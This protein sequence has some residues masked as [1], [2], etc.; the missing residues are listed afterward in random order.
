MK[1]HFIVLAAAMMPLAFFSCRK[2]KIEPRTDNVSLNEVA[3]RPV[4]KPSA[5]LDSGLVGRYEFDGNLKEYSGKLADAVASISGADNYTVDRKGNVNRAIKFNGRYGLDIFKVPLTFNTS[6]AVWVEY[7]AIAPSPNYFAKGDQGILPDF[8]QDNDNYW[9]VVSTPV[10]SGVP[11][12]SID[13][14][15]HHLVATYDGNELKFYVDGSFIGNSLN[16]C[17]LALPV[18]ATTHC[19]LGY[20]TQVGSVWYG[21]MDDLRYYTRVLSAADVKSLYKL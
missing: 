11:S 18:G 13:N 17:P 20:S 15:W 8:S 3:F 4:N 10:T 1:K 5:N 12:G 16:P 21:S 14:H 7:D 9:G 2:E 19:Q 6:V